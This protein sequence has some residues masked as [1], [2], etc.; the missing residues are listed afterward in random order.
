[1]PKKSIADVLEGVDLSKPGERERVVAEMRQI[2]ESRKAEAERVAREKGWPIRVEAPNGSIR[3]I[4]DLDERG[5]PVYFITHN[6]NAAISTGANILQASP[7]SLN[8]LNLI[9]GQWDGGSA[10]STHQEFGGRVTV[11]DGAASIDHATHVAGTM[12][13]SGV[14]SNAKGM[15]PSARIDSYDWNSDKTEM[16]A[17]AATLATDTNKVLISNHSYGY[18]AGWVYVGGGNP[19]RV[20]E[21]YG[22][23]TNTSGADSNFG[24]YNTYTRDSDSIAFSSPFYLMFRSA[25][26]DRG[27]NPSSG[28]SVGLSP[29]ATNVVTYSSSSHPAGD[30]IYRGGFETISFDSI[31]KNVIT[32]GSV[33]DAVSGTNRS[34]AAASLSSFS[35]TGPTDDGRIKPDVVANGDN[36]YSSLS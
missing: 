30:N 13:A 33:S 25:G 17:A 28:Q 19:Y 3:E 24:M 27:D 34:V 10:R 26:N 11:K 9:L 7:Y 21:W 20:Y 23:G 32:I 15:A 12:I 22:T 16:T 1:M 29:N 35:S 4:A 18:V 36:L 8:G 31:G 2:Q 5:N 14:V 6:V